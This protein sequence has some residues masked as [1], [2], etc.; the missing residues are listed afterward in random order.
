VIATI[1]ALAVIA[2]LAL[3]GAGYLFGTLGVTQRIRQTESSR[4][5]EIAALGAR[6]EERAEAIKRLEEEVARAAIELERAESK[7]RELSAANAMLEQRARDLEEQA[8][9]D[10]ESRRGDTEATELRLELKR[11]SQSMSAH[12]KSLTEEV[13]TA[14][15]GIARRAPDPTALRRDLEKMLE[16]VL[17]SGEKT[18]SLQGALRDALSPMME[19]ER[20]GNE[21]SNIDI[22]SGTLAELPQVLERISQRGGFS[23]VLLSDETGLPLAVTG[24]RDAESLAGISS[25]L[26]TMSERIERGGGAAPVAVMIQDVANQTTL[27]RIFSVGGSRYLLTAVTRSRWVVPGSLDPALSKIESMLGRDDAA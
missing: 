1:A 4:D 2:T 11:L 16:P 6:V 12:E 26:L 27:H 17:K 24:L 18:S 5:A 20:V 9:R 25:L 22:G 19:R 3:L 8:K 13:R 23:V 21:L 7:G 15:D 10:I 14:L